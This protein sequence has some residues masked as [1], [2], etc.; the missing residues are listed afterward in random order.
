LEYGRN[1][2][3]RGGGEKFRQHSGAFAARRFPGISQVL[4]GFTHARN[5]EFARYT[6]E[7]SH[8]NWVRVGVLVGVEMRRLDARCAYFQDLSSQFPFDF[9]G[10]DHSCGE[11]RYETTQRIMEIAVFGDKRWDFFEGSNRSSTYED[12]VAANS[13]SRIQFCEF[14][15]VIE[16][17]AT[18]HQSSARKNSVA[19]GLDNSFIYSAG[20]AEVVGVED[21]LLHLREGRLRE[22]KM[23]SREAR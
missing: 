11:A 13:E 2:P 4:H 18:R 6:A 16:G 3:S 15:R 1:H 17:R 5:S 20:E 22:E 12:Q 21:E 19:M 14:H 23:I 8:N 9:F 7:S 10:A